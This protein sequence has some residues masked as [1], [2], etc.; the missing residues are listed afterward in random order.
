M[1]HTAKG[2]DERIRL[3][4]I[5]CPIDFSSNSDAALP[6]ALTLANQHQAKLVILHC[7]E[8]PSWGR[9]ARRNLMKKR[10]QELVTKRWPSAVAEPLSW[11]IEIV[12]GDAE[13]AIPGKTAELSADLIVMH[14]RRRPQ[15][16]LLDSTAEAVIRLAPCPVLITKAYERNGGNPTTALPFQRVLVAYDFSGDSELAL[17]YGRWFAATYQAEFHL[18]H[19]LPEPQQQAV[20]ELSFLPIGANANYQEA[21]NRLNR[22]M[23]SADLMANNVR[24]ALRTGLPYR[25]ILTYAEEQ[26]IDLICMGASGTDFGMHTLF[27]SNTD[28]VLRQSRSA[29]LIARPLRPLH[30]D[31]P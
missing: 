1:T 22:L 23:A 17:T 25:E 3:R 5:V 26:R 10:I 9:Q 7:V 15:A 14:S 11:S 21:T 24:Q 20:P 28:R 8:Q 18:L 12:S 30:G 31:P 6:C 19:V 13:E 4:Q 2:T 29:L 16:A 27:G